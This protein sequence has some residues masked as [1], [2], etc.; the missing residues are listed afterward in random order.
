VSSLST[1]RLV[2]QVSLIMVFCRGTKAIGV[3][4]VGDKIA[5]AKGVQES[6]VARASYFVVLSAGAFGSPAILERSG[7]GASE[8]LKKS[9]IKQI[10]DLPGVGEHYMGGLLLFSITGT[11][12]R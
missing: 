11:A 2:K 9:D 3:E 7:I 5:K 6:S 10:V 1:Y 8:L 4:Y 12:R